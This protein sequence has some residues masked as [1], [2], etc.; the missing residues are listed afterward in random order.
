MYARHL[1]FCPSSGIA[2]YRRFPPP[3]MVHPA[4]DP[5][6]GPSALA[7]ALQQSEARLQALV[8]NIPGLVYQFRLDPDGS[9]AFPY[10]SH[11]C[12]AL[13]GIAPATLQAQPGQLLDMILEED[14]Q[15]YL[16]AMASS[17]ADMTPWNWE[18]RLWI[19][20]WKDTKWVNLRATPQSLAGGCVQWEGIMTNITA[21]K[22]E[23]IQLRH[24]RV[25]LAELSAHIETLKESER[26][27]IAREIHDDVGGNLSAIKMAL[28][29]LSTRLPPDDTALA[30]KAAY[31]DDLIDRTF[32]AVHRIAGD[33]RPS[34]LDCGIVEAL[35]W[36]AK[37]FE[38]LSGLPCVF[39]CTHK[40]INLDNQQATAVYR[41][42]QEALNN[43]NKHAGASEV[44]LEL[45]RL[46]ASLR[47][48]VLDDGRGF[49]RAD[50]N[51]PQSFGLR[52]MTERAQ[53]LGGDFSVVPMAGGGTEL[54]FTF[55]L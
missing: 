49:S 16:D 22:L 52:G 47:L 44:T 24:S 51:K 36:Q 10:L 5:A 13:L 46:P 28:S 26:A 34:I 4:S 37:E 54:R 39:V 14:R 55:P 27:R 20:D 17:G 18:G 41:I 2:V 40:E 8:G 29:M 38:K 42:V 45:K 31:V 1:A 6:T 15:A 19:E 48:R 3:A 7:K 12:R 11:G 50:R 32:D 23:Q 43:V 25:Q 9:M 35:A 33:L 53:A 30:E 21:S